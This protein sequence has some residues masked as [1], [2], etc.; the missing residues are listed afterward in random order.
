MKVA[1][2]SVVATGGASGI[3][4]ALAGRS[5]AEGAQDSFG[6]LMF[7]A[8]TPASPTPHPGVE[9]SFRRKAPTTTPGSAGPGVY[10]LTALTMSAAWAS[11]A[12][13][14]RA[15]SRVRPISR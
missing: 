6:P 10:A 11:I 5:T 8:L 13:S 9:A 14:L 15:S 12:A 3:G 1:G 4:R 2:K 7:S